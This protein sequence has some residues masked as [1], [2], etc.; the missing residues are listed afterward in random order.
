MSTAAGCWLNSATGAN[1]QPPQLER[2]WV[3][4]RRLLPSPVLF[5][6]SIRGASRHGIGEQHIRTCSALTSL[7][8]RVWLVTAVAAWRRGW[9]PTR[10]TTRGA[11]RG[12]SRRRRRSRHSR[13]SCHRSR[14]SRSFESLDFRLGIVPPAL[15]RKSISPRLTLAGRGSAVRRT[16]PSSSLQ[17]ASAAHAFSV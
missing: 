9:R 16:F 3:I 5:L 14:H 15:N 13:H 6:S 1:N 17:I 8:P 2:G 4:I 12:L 11:A 7:L 10:V